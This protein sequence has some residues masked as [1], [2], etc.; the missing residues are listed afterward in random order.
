MNRKEQLQEQYEDALFALLMDDMMEE[1]GKQLLE[2]NERLKQDPAAAVPDEVNARCIK[3]INRAFTRKRCRSVGRVTYKVFNT[4]AM[5]AV[6]CALLFV[7]AFAVSP[8]LRVNTLNFLI[9]V[10]DVATTLTL[11]GEA[12]RQDTGSVTS[13]SGGEVL[14]LGYRIPEVPEG[15]SVDYEDVTS[16]HAT[17]QYISGNETICFSVSRVNSGDQYMVDTEDAQVTDIQVGGYDGLLIEKIYRFEGNQT[18]DSAVV[19]WGDTD[20][21]TF[22]SVDGGNVDHSLILELANAVEFVGDASQ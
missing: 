14:L 12:D 3:T 20:Q 17:I 10:S 21:S 13:T 4:V 18:I 22:V 15:F 6:V 9:E 8:E 5:A 16:S 2:E 19:V 11:D 7:T 1:E